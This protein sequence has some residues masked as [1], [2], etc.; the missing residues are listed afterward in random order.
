M[1]AAIPSP[2]VPPQ[3]A[4]Q[5]CDIDRLEQIFARYRSDGKWEIPYWLIE[6]QWAYG[7]ASLRGYYHIDW[8]A[9]GLATNVVRSN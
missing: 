8:A 2:T 4:V 6:M 9:H 3:P 1:N 5:L 7:V